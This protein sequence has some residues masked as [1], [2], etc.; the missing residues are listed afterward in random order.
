MQHYGERA[1]RIGVVR[2]LIAAATVATAAATVMALA[3][4]ASAAPAMQSEAA[5]AAKPK[6]AKTK[7]KAHKT[8]APAGDVGTQSGSSGGGS[9]DFTGDGA[10]DILARQQNNGVLKVYP[11]SGTYNGIY[12]YTPATAINYGWGGLRWIGQGRFVGA[13]GSP[14]SLSDVISV[15]PNGVMTIYPHSG[16]YNGT[17]TLA[18][19]AV[20]VG[21]NWFVNDLIFTYDFDGN[22]WDD[23][24]ARRQGT[25][26]TYVYPH[27][28]AFNG[29]ATFTAPQ[30]VATGGDSDLEQNMGDFTGDGS[31]DLLFLQPDGWLAVFSLNEG[32]ID[33]VTQK[34]TGVAYAL[35]YGWET[36]NAI[37]L[38]DINRDNRPDVLGRVGVHTTPIDEYGH[39]KAYTN[40]GSWDPDPYGRAFGTLRQPVYIGSGWDTNDVIT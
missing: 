13:N 15:A 9:G 24:L 35:S 4:V 32:P 28:G 39:L 5:A 18:S 38:T 8:P 34:P 30:L 40:T 19:P 31:P 6:P 12:S 2:G 29:T 37:T 7:R 27:S 16:S 11:H 10:K 20:I 21:Y 14:R 22:G 26:D 36:I 23:I 25:G 1:R 3:P 33:P 17:S